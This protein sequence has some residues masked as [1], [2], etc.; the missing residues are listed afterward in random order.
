MHRALIYVEQGHKKDADDLLE[1][2]RQIHGDAPCETYALVINGDVEALIGKFDTIL[3]V[4]DENIRNYDQLA[5]ADVVAALHQEHDFSSII[6]A[7]T[8]WGRMLAPRVAMQLGTG[9]VADVTEIVH[10]DE[11][12]QLVRPAYSGR[13]MACI[14]ITG[15]GPVMLTVRPGV[16]RYAGGPLKTTKILQAEGITYRTGGIRQIQSQSK[17]VEYD[18]CDSDVLI[19]GGGGVAKDFEALKPL[20]RALRGKVSASRAIVDRGLVSRNVQ[21]GQSGKTVS[22]R[23]YMALGIHGAIQHVVALQDVDYIISVNTN[24]NA[25]ICSLSDIVV[26]GDAITFVE[27]LLKK[28]REEQG[29]GTH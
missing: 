23:L 19:S 9:L 26:E 22:P 5:V 27:N 16:F 10:H 7:G 14:E 18:I 8:Q 17:K 28:I 1:V 15:N 11:K 4:Q 20:A 12:L 21:V 25:P 29:N 2:A 13:M 24:V 6:V 3:L